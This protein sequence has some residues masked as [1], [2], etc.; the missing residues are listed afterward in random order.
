M[1]TRNFYLVGCIIFFA[2]CMTRDTIATFRSSSCQD[3]IAF[4][5]SNVRSRQLAKT[6]FQNAMCA[7]GDL[8]FG[9]NLRTNSF[10]SQLTPQMVNEGAH[11]GVNGKLHLNGMVYVGGN[12]LVSGGGIEEIKHLHIEK[13]LELS[14]NLNIPFAQVK[15][16]QDAQIGGNINVSSLTVTGSL[17]T[18]N[19]IDENKVWANKYI[20]SAVE[21]P[22]PCKCQ[23]TELID[24][25]TFIENHRLIN[26]NNT[27]GLSENALSNI[28]GDLTLELSCGKFFL[29]NIQSNQGQVTLRIVENTALFV[30]GNITLGGAFAVEIAPGAKLDLFIGGNVN[31]MELVRL[32]NPQRP[33]ALRIYVGSSGSINW[34]EK[35]ILAGNLYAPKT[36]LVLNGSS[37]EIYGAMVV[38][39]VL[40]NSDLTIHYDRA[41]ISE[42]ENSAR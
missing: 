17:T 5:N 19:E 18:P 40:T 4:E 36:D 7:C 9:G 25:A 35:S 8:T 31:V 14:G 21:V 6:A 26:D 39:H 41:I 29:S 12:L 42:S 30:A 37:F 28:R 32:G 2:A 3:N 1:K 34:P 10:D 38:N 23:S 15:V 22:A 16:G 20:S 24:V 13:N 11:V 33:Q 27:I